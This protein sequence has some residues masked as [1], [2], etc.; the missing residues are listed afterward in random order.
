VRATARHLASFGLT[1]LTDAS[2]TNGRRQLEHL[3]G[4]D[5]GQRLT[6]MTAAPLSSAPAGIEVGPVKI[7]LDDIALPS[8]DDLTAQIAD[9]HRRQ[10]PIAVHC[11][12]RLQLVLTLAALDST[13]A[14][15][16]DRIEH[17]AIVPPELV[18][19]LVRHR[20]TVVTQPAFVA[21]RGDQYLDHVDADDQPWL[22]RLKGLLDAGIPLLASSDSPFGP[23]DPWLAIGAARDRLSSRRRPVAADEA[24]DT[25]TA[26]GL[27]SRGT[28]APGAPADLC[29]VGEPWAQLLASPADT[30]VVA[31]IARGRLLYSA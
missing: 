13:G 16:G 12:T 28:I 3:A 20:L 9:A 25:A 5:L 29:V 31:T 22:Y 2:V 11:V 24:I 21:A 10:V 30:S 26:L 8:L 17:G 7:L 27:Y 19:G 4:L 1:S 6:C 15:D 23:V 14:I 18:D